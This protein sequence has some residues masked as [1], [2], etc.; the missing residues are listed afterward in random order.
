M[1]DDLRDQ[2]R[3]GSTAPDGGC[4]RSGVRVHQGPRVSNFSSNDYLALAAD[5][6][7]GRA[8]PAAR[9]FGCGAGASPLVS[10]YLPP[11]RTLERALARWEETEAALVFPSG[12]AANLAL[13]SSLAGP[14]QVSLRPAGSASATD[15]IFS[16]TLNHASLIDG[17]RLAHAR[18]HVYRHADA[19]HLEELLRTEGRSARR[20][21]I[22]TDS[23]FSMDGDF[24]PLAE[25]IDLAHRFD[26]LLL[27]DEA[28]RRA[29]WGRTAGDC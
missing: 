6:R 26:A 9:L 13:V 29:C 27:V 4:T 28:T 17:C 16:D 1:D 11:L 14:G 20:R 15:A 12:Y 2:R 8:P 3:R 24:A 22:V 23:V 5:P 7:L 18:V 19:N 10:G 21:L 25:L